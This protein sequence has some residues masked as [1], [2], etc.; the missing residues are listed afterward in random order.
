MEIVCGVR[1]GIRPR[2][3]LQRVNDAIDRAIAKRCRRHNLVIHPKTRTRLGFKRAAHVPR[4]A[5]GDE[6]T[7]R[8]CREVFAPKTHTPRTESLEVDVDRSFGTFARPEVHRKL[9]KRDEIVRGRRTVFAEG[10]AIFLHTYRPGFP[11]PDA[12]IAKAAVD[13]SD[14]VHRHLLVALEIEDILAKPLREAHRAIVGAMIEVFRE[15]GRFR[16]RHDS[17]PR[18]LSVC[19]PIHRVRQFVAVV[20][21]A[22]RVVVAANRRRAFVPLDRV[23]ELDL[24]ARLPEARRVDGEHLLRGRHLPRRRLL[25][26]RTALVATVDRAEFV[27]DVPV[28]DRGMM[29]QGARH[30]TKLVLVKRPEPVGAPRRATARMGNGREEH[31]VLVGRLAHPRHVAAEDAERVDAAFTKTSK[32]PEEPLL[33]GAVLAANPVPCRALVHVGA[34]VQIEA[35][36]DRLELPKAVALGKRIRNLS[37]DGDADGHRDERRLVGAPERHPVARVGECHPLLGTRPQ[38]DLGLRKVRPGN[39]GIARQDGL[40]GLG[41]VVPHEDAHVKH[42][43]VLPVLS[44]NK[45]TA[46]RQFLHVNGARE[47]HVDGARNPRLGIVLPHGRVAPR[48]SHAI[49]PS[50]HDDG[51]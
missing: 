37:P 29:T 6:R 39:A 27:R 17:L 49:L 38:R 16:L 4:G 20:R 13:E 41:A 50:H 14:E 9:Q 18:N 42:F 45:A 34:T 12:R 32:L 35:V 44:R 23:A 30:F 15:G 8:I 24:T 11:C 7:F 43:R 21:I 22:D 31:T 26:A 3:I 36:A 46:V 19:I 47:L 33:V 10:R 28:D 40:H 1:K 51:V 5:A 48:P 25:L 2:L